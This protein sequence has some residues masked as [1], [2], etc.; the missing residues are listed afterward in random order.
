MLR[1]N[2]NAAVGAIRTLKSQDCLLARKNPGPEKI[3]R[4]G[5]AAE[6]RSVV[7]VRDAC[8]V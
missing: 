6:P 1:G 5:K 8:T 4:R 3:K 7:P 2:V